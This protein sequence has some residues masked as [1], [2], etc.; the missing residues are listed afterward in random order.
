MSKIGF[1]QKWHAF[2]NERSNLLI[3]ELFSVG[4]LSQSMAYLNLA[5]FYKNIIFFKDTYIF[6][7]LASFSGDDDKVGFGA[8]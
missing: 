3:L 8:I 1:L 6:I 7:H 2:E 5:F 4:T